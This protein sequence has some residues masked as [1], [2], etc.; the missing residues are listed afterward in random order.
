MKAQAVQRLLYEQQQFPIF[1]NR[2]YDSAVAARNCTRGDI[3]LVEDLRSG[4]V[5]N[6]AFEPAL[7]QYDDHYQNEQAV[8]GMFQR[9]LQQVAEVVARG[10]GRD[11]LVEVGC[12]KGHF[13]ETLQAGGFDITGFDPAYEGSNPGVRKEVFSE[14]VMSPARGLI[15]RHVLEHIPDPVAFLGQLARANGGAGRI[16][17][18]V[19]CFDWICR[20]RA[21]FDVFYEHVNYFRL[22]D[23]HRMFG[24][25][26]ESG[27][28]FGG[29]YLYV[30]A[31][32]DTLR[33]PERDPADAV[34]F[35]DDFTATLAHFDGV[36][37]CAIWGGASKGV[38][39]ALLK[40]RRGSP[41]GTVIDINP[42]KQGKFLPGT[43]L[44]VGAPAEEIDR[45]PT[46]TPVFVMNSNYI[47]EIRA[48]SRGRFEL[49]PIDT[50]HKES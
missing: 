31:E 38:I 21:W 1:Q 49:I 12:G 43:G 22:T 47:E 30:V 7:M 27:R 5:Y 37:D 25:V 40:E 42:A 34:A 13:L 32:L 10:L 2:M 17:I 19:P 46:G 14:G 45:L 41:V 39:F 23:F 26:V 6:A 35:P 3:R 15:L 48:M 8:S 9:H 33:Q 28:L 50:T 44:R 4:L 11:R 29:Q 36:R 16:Y 18:E 20:R 24:R